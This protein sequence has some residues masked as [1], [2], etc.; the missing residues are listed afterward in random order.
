MYVYCERLKYEEHNKKGK[1][2]FL[3]YGKLFMLYVLLI[4]TTTSFLCRIENLYIHELFS[5]MNYGIYYN[6]M[7]YTLYTV[8]HISLM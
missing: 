5:L 3:S 1:S 8:K 6:I 7:F 4:E 2:K